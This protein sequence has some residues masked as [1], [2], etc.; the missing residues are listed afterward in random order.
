MCI[1]GKEAP[2]VKDGYVASEDRAESDP[3]QKSQT[4]QPK[5]DTLV[6]VFKNPAAM[7]ARLVCSVLVAYILGMFIILIIVG[8]YTYFPG[9]KDDTCV[10]ICEKADDYCCTYANPLPDLGIIEDVTFTSDGEKMHGWWIPA[11][12]DVQYRG[13]LL[14]NHGSAYNVAIMYRQHRYAYLT[15]ELG[16]DVFVYDYPGYGKSEGTSSEDGLIQSGKDAFKWLME[17]TGKPSSDLLVLGRSIGGQM[18]IDLAKEYS[19]NKQGLKGLILQSTFKSMKETAA[20]FFPMY[21]WLVMSS[22]AVDM[23]PS[24]DKMPDVTSCVHHFHSK[25]DEWVPFSHGE[26]LHAMAKSPT[27]C[28]VW[29]ADEDMKHDDAMSDEEKASLIEWLQKIDDA[30]DVR[31]QL[32]LPF[33]RKAAD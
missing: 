12:P 9:T 23:G 30:A 28:K 3:A 11:N 6:D 22:F 2:V 19:D 1:Q 25:A 5:R 17:K 29:I 21:E 24:K 20:S 14:Y 27:S 33:A 7:A 10:D 13:S 8:T 18:A 16:V 4:E 31:R 26:D 15:Q 32:R